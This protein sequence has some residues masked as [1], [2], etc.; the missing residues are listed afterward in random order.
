MTQ[1]A[2]LKK[3]KRALRREVLARRD[4]M[5]ASERARAGA[6]IV[7]RFVALSEVVDARTVMA[8]WSF[9][10][11]VDTGPLLDA[12][13]ARGVTL[14]L[15][16]IEDGRLEPRRW[17]P[18][19]PLE[20]TWFGAREPVTGAPVDPATIDVV[21]VP[22]VAFDRAGGRVGYGGGFY[23]RF[24][25]RAR[26][27]TSRVAVAFACQLVEEPVPAASFDLRIDALVT[28]AE[29]LRFPRSHDAAGAPG[30]ST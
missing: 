21:A 28:E 20:E 24:L 5:P 26:P 27:D 7:E 1:S 25:G 4:A 14:V 15:P 16:T 17:A 9:G 22:G 10:S 12:L 18:G 23:D 30:T 19:D 13:A 6:T 2:D 3:A 11:E 8:F 29:V